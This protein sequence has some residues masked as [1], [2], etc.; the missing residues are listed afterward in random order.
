MTIVQ[1]TSTLH[2]TLWFCVDPVWAIITDSRCC[3]EK[4]NICT[5][6]WPAVDH[7]TKQPARRVN[8]CTEGLVLILFPR[9]MFVSRQKKHNAALLFESSKFCFAP[10]S[11]TDGRRKW[12]ILT[13]KKKHI[14]EYK[15]V[16]SDWCSCIFW[17]FTKGDSWTWIS[18]GAKKKK[19]IKKLDLKLDE[20]ILPN[21]REKLPDGSARTHKHNLKQRLSWNLFL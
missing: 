7:S 5:Y 3:E 1:N 19:P 12:C 18:L 15:H 10:R 16:F 13:L 21:N 11:W 14:W 9:L 6:F 4:Q 20:W 8:I 17:N 2:R